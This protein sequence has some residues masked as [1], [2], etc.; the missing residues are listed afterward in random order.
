MQ[1]SIM[2]VNIINCD[3]ETVK[4][5]NELLS[6]I[7]DKLKPNIQ[8]GFSSLGRLI[9]QERCL[10]CSSAIF[11]PTFTLLSIFAFSPAASA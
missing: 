7:S 1:R 11:P 2:F 9:D 6:D 4:K 3:L 5:I 8:K 10:D